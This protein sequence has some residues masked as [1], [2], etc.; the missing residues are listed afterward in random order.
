MQNN[1][2]THEMT[3]IRYAGFGIRLL[4]YIIDN[5]ILLI[6]VLIVNM[7][8]FIENNLIGTSFFSRQI[9]FQYTTSDIIIYIIHSFYFVLLTY[10][11]NATLGKHILNL[12]VVTVN[13]DNKHSFIDIL[14]RETI[15]RFLSGLVLNIG[16][17]II[18]INKDKSALHDMLADT[19]VVY[20][21]KS[22]G[23]RLYNDNRSNNIS[24]DYIQVDEKNSFKIC[25]GIPCHN[26]RLRKYGT[27]R[28]RG[29][30]VRQCGDTAR[31][32]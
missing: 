8:N 23:K 32:F 2:N 15:G 5:L 13:E 10:F 19:R 22:I 14:Y 17:L 4:A 11:T 12:K 18:F 24:Y 29:Q 31:Q 7:F 25:S 9:L 20:K 21:K 26:A 30:R 27:C 1:E 16:Y 6:A 28:A 3:E